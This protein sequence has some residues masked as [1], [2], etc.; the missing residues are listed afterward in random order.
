[1]MKM[2][3]FL[4]ALIFL[5]VKGFARDFLHIHKC[6][7]YNIQKL[8]LRLLKTNNVHEGILK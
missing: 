5:V 8:V 7:V 4:D 1:M 3:I 6:E 2:T